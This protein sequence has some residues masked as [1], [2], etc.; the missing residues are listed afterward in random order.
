MEKQTT[1]TKTMKKVTTKNQVMDY[2]Q[3]SSEEYEERVL[4]QYW[5]WCINYG[6]YHSIIQQLLANR[7]VNKW[8][9]MEF[10]K[11]EI[12]FLNIVNVVPQKT[13]PL[14]N[15]YKACT[16]EIMGIY[17]KPLIEAIK[18]NIDFIKINTQTN[19]IYYA[20]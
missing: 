13:E 14:R 15:H 2:L 1:K 3:W 10:N 9:L 6:Q 4:Q 18:K 12:H 17:Q 20:N 19:T 8:F 11:L 7:A 16:S 5:A